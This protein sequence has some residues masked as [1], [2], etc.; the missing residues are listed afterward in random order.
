MQR[1]P[2]LLFPATTVAAGIVIAYLPLAAG[3]PAAALGL[4][5]QALAA[6]AGRYGAGRLG[7][8]CGHARLV[9]PGLAVS[10]LGM[11]L[12]IG[13]G[14]PAVPV[15]AMAVFGIGFGILQSATYALMVERAPAGGR[16]AVS[17]LWNLA[18]DLGYGLGPLAFA[19]VVGT[20]GYAPAFALTGLVLLT[21][22]RAARRVR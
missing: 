2:A 16:G 5:V 7:D 20:S 19:T 18:Y 1:R 3:G 15:V 13:V 11:V 9:W 22:L 4:F 17:A 14:L 12:L 8:R 21:R 10:G 6:T